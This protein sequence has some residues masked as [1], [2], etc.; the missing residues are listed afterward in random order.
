MYRCLGVV[1][2]LR[3]MSDLVPLPILK[4]IYF[5]LVYP[6]LIYGVE[7]WGGSSKTEITR[8]SGLVRKCTSLLEFLESP[9]V[10]KTY[11]FIN[12]NQIYR[13]FCLLRTFKYI[14]LSSVPHF[15]NR[16]SNCVPNHNFETRFSGNQKFK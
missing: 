9:T 5:T 2:I 3:R 6:H 11:F 7:V 15:A 4:S 1:G 16:Y 8:L 12:F 14:R 10:S 13:Y